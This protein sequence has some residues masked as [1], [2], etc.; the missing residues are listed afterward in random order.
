[1]TTNQRKIIHIDMDAFFA[2]VEQRDNVE[3]Q[4]K[5]VIVGGQPNSRGVVAA[6]SYEARQFGIHSAMPCSRAY[7]LCPNAIFVPPRFE[8]YKAV[9]KIIQEIFWRYATDVEPLSL[10][11]AYLDVSHNTAFDGSATRLA[12][13][14]KKSIYAETNLVASAGVSYNKFLAKIASDMDKPNGLYVIKPSQGEA[15]IAALPIG[16]FY[17]VGPAIE[18]KMLKLGIKTGR[19]LRA[20]S[21]LELVQHFG[22]SGNYFFNIAQG[23]DQRPVR[24]S[25]TRKSLSKETTFKHD[26][27]DTSLLLEHLNTLAKTVFDNLENQLFVAKTITLKVKYADFKTVTRSYSST[28][29]F[30]DLAQIRAILPE[31]LSRT[32]AGQHGV[33]LVGLSASSLMK[34]GA[35]EQK[36]QLEF[37]ME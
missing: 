16:K 18:A 28:K 34:K 12:E 5:P 7:R 21:Q 35:R 19:D 24:S 23:I 36:D 26:I 10:D 31:L 1:M 33:R 37:D 32:E 9:S 25:R 6:C 29:R 13:A 27:N 14:I 3:L 11:E 15:F 2:S 4:G 22:K 30:T 8:A 20:K 17:G